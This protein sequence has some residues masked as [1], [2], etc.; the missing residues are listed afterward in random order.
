MGIQVQIQ[1]EVRQGISLIYV[2]KG[3]LVRY[4]LQAT[5]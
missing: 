2:L 5:T 1:V 3:D 4:I